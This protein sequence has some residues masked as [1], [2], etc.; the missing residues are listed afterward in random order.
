MAKRKQTNYRHG[1]FDI[2][3][4]RHLISKG[5]YMELPDGMPDDEVQ[6][7]IDSFM[8]SLNKPQRTYNPKSR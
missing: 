4:V 2:P 7:R 8:S 5:L 3:K 1:S 6:R